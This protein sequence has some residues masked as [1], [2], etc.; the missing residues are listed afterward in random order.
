MG[1]LKSDDGSIIWFVENKT[2]R[3]SLANMFLSI[4]AHSGF[5]ICYNSYSDDQKT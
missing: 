1:H 5:P 4:D 3:Q 2:D